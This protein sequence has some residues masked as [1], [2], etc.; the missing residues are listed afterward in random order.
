MT[1]RCFAVVD[2][3]AKAVQFYGFDESGKVVESERLVLT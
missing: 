2:L 3:E 1:M